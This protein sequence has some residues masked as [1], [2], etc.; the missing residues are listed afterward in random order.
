[1]TKQEWTV[2]SELV[3]ALKGLIAWHHAGCDPSRKALLRAETI[4]AKVEQYQ[5]IGRAL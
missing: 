4:L 2:F 5:T 1:M 3:G